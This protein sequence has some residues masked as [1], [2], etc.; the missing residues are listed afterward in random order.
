MKKKLISKTYLRDV[1]KYNIKL[2]L[3]EDDY[4]VSVKEIIKTDYPFH[5]SS[6]LCVIDNGYYILELIP[7]NENYAMRVYFNQK[8]EILEYYFDISL[9][10][11]IDSETKIPYYDDLYN[12][13]IVLNGE[14][15]ILDEDEL[16]SA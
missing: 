1:E 16:E 3:S 7:K 9:K 4:Y 8:K 14:V 5:I 12:D 10:N 2:Y 13:V 6:G 11:G 15:T